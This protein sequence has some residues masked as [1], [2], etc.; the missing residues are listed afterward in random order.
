MAERDLSEKCNRARIR[1]IVTDYLALRVGGSLVPAKENVDGLL[2]VKM[3]QARSP[4]P[5]AHSCNEVYQAVL[6]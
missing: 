5:V 4:L 1:L 3:V 6:G 2:L